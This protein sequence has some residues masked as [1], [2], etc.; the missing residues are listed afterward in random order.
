MT[1]GSKALVKT[2]T[3]K[4]DGFIN[5]LAR[6]FVSAWLFD[7]FYSRTFEASHSGPNIDFWEA[8]LLVFAIRIAFGAGFAVVRGDD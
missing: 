5:G 1:N 8:V 6:I 3:V 7:L 2:M 4:T